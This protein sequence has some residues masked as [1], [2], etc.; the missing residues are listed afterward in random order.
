MSIVLVGVL[1][2]SFRVLHPP[3]LVLALAGLHPSYQSSSKWVSV[4]F[5]LSTSVHY[6]RGIERED[7]H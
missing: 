3:S 1:E 6:E 7:K 4:N 5:P 2:P